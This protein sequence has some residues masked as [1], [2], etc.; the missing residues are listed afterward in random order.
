MFQRLPEGRSGVALPTLEL[1]HICVSVPVEDLHP[2]TRVHVA[3]KMTIG[4]LVPTTEHN[5]EHILREIGS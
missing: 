2:P 3:E 1:P 4:R 5:H